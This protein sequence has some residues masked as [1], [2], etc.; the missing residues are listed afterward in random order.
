MIPD[1]TMNI[2]APANGTPAPNDSQTVIHGTPGSAIPSPIVNQTPETPATPPKEIFLG[3]RKFNSQDELLQYTRDLQAQVSVVDQLKGVLSPQVKAADPNEELADLMY[4]NPRRYTEII[5]ERSANRAL[6]Q[7][8]ASQQAQKIRSD[9]F[10]EYNDLSNHSE[11][12]DMY[13][14]SMQ[15][16]LA[17]LSQKD[18]TSRLANAVRAKLANIRGNQP[19]TETLPNG[20]PRVVGQGSG[21]PAP[22]T[23]GPRQSMA[24]QLKAHQ[25]RGKK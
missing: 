12:V 7:F 24:D 21:V 1:E 25:K 10:T 18:A 4:S 5:E 20:S 19:A 17:Q 13:Y 22:L 23:P 15:K 8:Q 3:T 2:P 11:L 16:E 14:T 9:F 6:Q